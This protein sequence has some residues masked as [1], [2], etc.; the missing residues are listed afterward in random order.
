MRETVRKSLAVCFG[1]HSPENLDPVCI[2]LK[3]IAANGCFSA[4]SLEFIRLFY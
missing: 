3:P 4:E 2:A 1:G